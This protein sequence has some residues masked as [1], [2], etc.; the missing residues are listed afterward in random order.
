[1]NNDRKFYISELK[2]EECQC[3]EWK[4]SGMSFCYKCYVSLP[5]LVQKALY[6]SFGQGYEEAYDEAIK[7]LSD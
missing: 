7:Y 3:G 2:S 1:M 6:T 5:R 4:R